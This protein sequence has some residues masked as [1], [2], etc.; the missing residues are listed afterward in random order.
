MEIRAHLKITVV[1]RYA[2]THE[3]DEGV[4]YMSMDIIMEFI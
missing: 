2:I 3:T 4:D 1:V